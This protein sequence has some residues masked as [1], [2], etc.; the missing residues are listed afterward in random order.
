MLFLWHITIRLS[1]SSV[2]GDLGLPMA[3]A[4]AEA[5]YSLHAWVRPPDSLDVL[6]HVAHT[7]HQD[8]ADMAAACDIVGLCVSTDDDVRELV[9]ALAPH[10]RPGAVIVNH[11][12][13]TPA[14]ARELGGA[15]CKEQRLHFFLDAPVT[16][17]RGGAQT[18][19]LTTFVGGPAEAVQ[20]CEPVFDS[21]SAHVLHLGPHGMGQLT[22]LVNNTLLMMNR[23][24]VA[25]VIDLLSA[26][27]IDPIP[28]SW[29]R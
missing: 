5:G 21:F 10:M 12:T 11:G 24:N 18:R 2:W 19:S 1:G 6:S 7:G 3:E 25:D 13:G 15:Y 20:L 4:I 16:G 23:A 9:T 14:V 28:P 29:K 17:A 8:L 22:K 26:G 27:G